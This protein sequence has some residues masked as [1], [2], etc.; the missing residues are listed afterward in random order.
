M[1]FPIGLASKTLTFGRYSSALGSNRGGSVSVGFDEAM[2]HVPTGE[3]ITS[4][5]DKVTIDPGTGVASVTVP[6]TVTDQ[7]VAKW[8]TASPV[9]NQRLKITVNLPGYPPGSKYVDIHPND[10]PVMDY[11]QLTPYSVPGGLTVVRAEMRTWV[12]LSGDISLEQALTA[13]GLGN[14][15]YATQAALDDA[16]ARI[17]ALEAQVNP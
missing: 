8:D 4:G 6:I 16:L 15:P 10:P 1:A 5:E 13:L 9:F 17:A 12:G 3:V 7:L 11:D 14:G 2:L